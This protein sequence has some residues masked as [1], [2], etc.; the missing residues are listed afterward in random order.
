MPRGPTS[1]QTDGEGDAP[2]DSV[3]VTP[4]V[5]CCHV[6]PPSAER[7]TAPPCRMRQRLAGFDDTITVSGAPNENAFAGAAAAPASAGADADF[8]TRASAFALSA[9]RLETSALAASTV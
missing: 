6:A 3:S 7:C 4:V 5:C 8:C 9:V 1:Q 2:A